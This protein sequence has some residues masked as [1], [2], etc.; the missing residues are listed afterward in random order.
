MTLA[1]LRWGITIPLPGVSLADH[2]EILREIVDFGYTDCWTMET[3]GFD[4]FT[5][6]A[7]A[8][9]WAPE[10]RLGTAI[11][12]VFTRGPALLA[13]SAAALAD[14]APGR[15]VLGI[16][17]SSETMVTG[18]NGLPFDAPYERVR[19]TLR[20]LRRAL[21]GERV[22]E[23]FPSFESHGFRL[24][25]PPEAVPPVYLA[26]LQRDML[27]LAAREADGV[28]LS[29]VGVRDL[30]RVL[31][32]L[33]EGAR[34]RAV[35]PSPSAGVDVVLRVG[36]WPTEDRA[37][38]REHARRV[39]AGYLTVPAYA[40]MTE[41]L[42]HGEVLAPIARAW[43]AGDRR[44][45]VEAVPDALVDALFI[46]GSPGACREQLEAF[47]AA[48]V[49]TPVV[50]LLSADLDGRSLSEVL[51]ALRPPEAAGSDAR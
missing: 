7:L 29:L 24:D 35:A 6:L 16:G 43:K 4:A 10:L 15:F 1:P 13:Q 44:A 8:A 42:G 14:A 18:W 30:P 9:A 33:D 47:R 11:A 46:H 37:R 23:A 39:V 12:S 20:F 5:P 34:S 28:M 31:E 50:S 32:T 45:A 3:S 25:R 17:S 21:A 36:V 27:R 40:A 51:R 49:A 26:A 41:W 19:D 22:D 2:R 48:G 38:A